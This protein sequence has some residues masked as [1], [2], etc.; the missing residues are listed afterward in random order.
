MSMETKTSKKELAGKSVIAA[1]DSEGLVSSNKTVPDNDPPGNVPCTSNGTTVSALAAPIDNA[2]AQAAI[3]HFGRSI[4]SPLFKSLAT[5]GIIVLWGSL[6]KDNRI[7]LIEWFWRCIGP[8]GSA[9]IPLCN[10]RYGSLADKPSRAKIQLCLLWS[11]SGQTRAWLDCQLSAKSRLMRCNII[12][13]KRKTT[14][15]R[16]LRNPI[17][18][19]DQAAARSESTSPEG[20]RCSRSAR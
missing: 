7:D 5:L 15:R 8:T 2:N 1:V 11:K 18:C 13:A 17:R 14:S 20:C 16:S 19:F 4:S 6:K 12:G 3:I 9:A 10:V